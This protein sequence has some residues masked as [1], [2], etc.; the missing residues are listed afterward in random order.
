M[1][2][3]SLAGWKQYLPLAD[4][5]CYVHP[6]SYHLEPSHGPGDAKLKAVQAAYVILKPKAWPPAI[7]VVS[8]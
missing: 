2:W 4:A 7:G 8:Y 5:F 3:V 6:R 1:V